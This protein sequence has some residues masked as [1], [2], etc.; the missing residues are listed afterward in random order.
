MMPGSLFCSQIYFLRCTKFETKYL[1]SK[2]IMKYF[3]CKGTTTFEDIADD[4]GSSEDEE[5]DEHETTITEEDEEEMA[6]D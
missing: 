5:D 1:V 6:D 4:N 2:N 3:T